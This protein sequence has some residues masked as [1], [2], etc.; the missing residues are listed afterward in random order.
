MVGL[1]GISIVKY[2]SSLYIMIM[3]SK[4]MN[5][6]TGCVYQFCASI[7]RGWWTGQRHGRVRWKSLK[8]LPSEDTNT[9]V[10]HG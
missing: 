3:S 1:G 7:V 6:D 9:R 10:I 8:R 2:G 4:G 5:F